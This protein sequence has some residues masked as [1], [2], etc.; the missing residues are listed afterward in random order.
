MARFKRFVVYARTVG[1]PDK[2]VRNAA[3][4]TYTN[5]SLN[6]CNNTLLIYTSTC[7]FILWTYY[8]ALSPILDK[9]RPFNTRL[10]P[11]NAFPFHVFRAYTCS[12]GLGPWERSRN[13]LDKNTQHAPLPLVENL[14]RGHSAM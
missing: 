4:P 12:T 1:H 9:K 14:S 10:L 5:K 7:V 11:P 3:V 6:K 2:L 13:K 8:V